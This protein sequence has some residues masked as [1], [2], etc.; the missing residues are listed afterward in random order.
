MVDSRSSLAPLALLDVH[1]VEHFN[2]D[3]ANEAIR[4]SHEE[5]D[6]D[7]HVLPSAA[8]LFKRS[9]IVICADGIHECWPPILNVDPSGPIGLLFANEL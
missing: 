6:Q 4:V 9:V 5:L 2:N 1:S 7:D 8:S 3:L